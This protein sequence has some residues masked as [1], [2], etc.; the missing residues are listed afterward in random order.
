MMYILLATISM[1]FLNLSDFQ[2]I[3][4]SANTSIHAH[5]SLSQLKSIHVEQKRFYDKT[6]LLE[7]ILLCAR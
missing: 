3:Q 6:S 1:T 2:I 5:P 4:I 7:S